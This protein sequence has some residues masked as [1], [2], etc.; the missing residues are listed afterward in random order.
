M[1][2]F[3]EKFLGK[4]ALNFDENCAEMAILI[5]YINNARCVLEALLV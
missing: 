5:C 4:I 2:F 1:Q 3:V